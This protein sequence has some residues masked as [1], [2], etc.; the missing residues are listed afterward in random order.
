MG[1]KPSR[2]GESFRLFYCSCHYRS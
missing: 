1:T 2:V